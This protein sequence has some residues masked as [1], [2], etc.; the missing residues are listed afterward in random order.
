[1]WLHALSHP[2]DPNRKGVRD[3]KK[4][5]TTATL[6]LLGLCDTVP[7]QLPMLLLNLTSSRYLLII[8]E[9]VEQINTGPQFCGILVY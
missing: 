6:W 1:M 2:L 7:L 4:V 3:N 8:K 9:L 5:G